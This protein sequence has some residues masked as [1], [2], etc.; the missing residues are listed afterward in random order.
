M[1][2][3]DQLCRR[4]EV[5]LAAFAALDRRYYLSSNPTLADRD[6]YATRQERLEQKRYQFYAELKE[7]RALMLLRRCRSVPRQSALH[8]SR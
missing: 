6:A 8:P 7:I 5:E 3:E 2:T 1:E 4:Y